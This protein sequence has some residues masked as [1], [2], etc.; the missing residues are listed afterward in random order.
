ME[1]VKCKCPHCKQT[2]ELGITGT[3]DGC[4]E[5][6]GIVRNPIDH[7]IINMGE[8]TFSEPEEA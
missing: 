1:P 3:V 6:L 7:T 4:D 2:Y 5:C 8:L